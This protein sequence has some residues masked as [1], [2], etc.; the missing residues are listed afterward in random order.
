MTGNNVINELQMLPSKQVV[1]TDRR[2]NMTLVN[3]FANGSSLFLDIRAHA[4]PVLYTAMLSH[5]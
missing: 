1:I 2:V 5:L 4:Q 3:E